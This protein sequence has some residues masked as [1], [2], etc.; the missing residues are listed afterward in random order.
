M[1]MALCISQHIISHSLSSPCFSSH[2]TEAYLHTSLE[3][4]KQVTIIILVKFPP[5]QSKAINLHVPSSS[6]LLILSGSVTP[7]SQNNIN[8]NYNT[9]GFHLSEIVQPV[10]LNRESGLK[11][12]YRENPTLQSKVGQLS[13]KFRNLTKT[14]L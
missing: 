5:L 3:T 10:H 13:L 8:T 11:V 6:E 4:H 1:P 7:I 12:R 14:K 9:A 2:A